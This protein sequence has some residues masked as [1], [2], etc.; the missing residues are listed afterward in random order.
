MNGD[1]GFL[2]ILEELKALHLKKAQDYGSDDD[3]LQNIRSAAKCGL[4]PH[5][6]AWVRALDKVH[7]INRW[8]AKG[9]LENES[10]ED[11]L[12]DLAAYAV[13]VL[14]LLREHQRLVNE[15]GDPH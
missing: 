12:M 4:S 13:I 3:P 7:R 8:Y 9:R 1:P 2:A 5:H 10:V 15:C 6:A 14:R 11:S